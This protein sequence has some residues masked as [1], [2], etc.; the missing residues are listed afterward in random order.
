MAKTKK[1]PSDAPMANQN[2]HPVL[3][4]GVTLTKILVL[5]IAS[6][7]FL[8]S[9]QAGAEWYDIALR[10]SLA[11]IVVGLFGWYINWM[12][13]KWIVSYEIK[14]LENEEAHILDEK[15]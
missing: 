5:I 15:I 6:L 3:E 4:A 11:I 7:I 10:T 13:G 9:I 1:P 2:V 8:L 12:L 14:K